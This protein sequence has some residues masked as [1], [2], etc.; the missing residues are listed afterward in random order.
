MTK[1]IALL[2]GDGIGPEIVTEAVK[3]I[4]CLQQEFGF[5][6]EL[7]TAAIGGAG[8]DQSGRPLP[9]PTLALCERADA[10]LFGAIGG[11]QYDE[12]ERELR[13]EKGLLELR[14]A[15]SLFSN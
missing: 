8:Y 3:I 12:L 4:H 7:E 6:T 10:V 15:L 14:S 11:P 13:P 5:N 2:A 9:E 1:K